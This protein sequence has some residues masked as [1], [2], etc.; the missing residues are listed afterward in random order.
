MELHVR[1]WGNSAAVLLPAAMLEQL[2]AHIGDCLKVTFN[3][4]K[5]ALEVA[6]PHYALN[7]LLA[8]CDQAAPVPADLQEWENMPTVGKE[9][10]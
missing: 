7:D 6:K 3:G 4:S 10:L 2:Q 1:K 8:Q 9:V 5:A